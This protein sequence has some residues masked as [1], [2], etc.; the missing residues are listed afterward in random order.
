M[1]SD[2]VALP[3]E[4][5]VE[6]Q[7]GVEA[8]FARALRMADKRRSRTLRRMHETDRARAEAAARLSAQS[9][10]GMHADGRCS[11]FA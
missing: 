11:I 7:E 1:Q 3:G 8:K 10:G 4:G 2:R 6:E 5:A 9:L